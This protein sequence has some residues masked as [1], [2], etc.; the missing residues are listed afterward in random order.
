[1]ELLADDVFLLFPKWKLDQVL[2][3]FFFSPKGDLSDLLSC[4]LAAFFS[5]P[6]PVALLI[7][8]L[9]PSLSP[10]SISFES[11]SAS[12]S[13]ELGRDICFVSECA[14]EGGG[15]SLEKLGSEVD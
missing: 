13:S 5:F 6:S 11:A 9:S 7:G 10:G 2:F 12:E 4:T 15:V 3:N 14:G 1:M 8:S